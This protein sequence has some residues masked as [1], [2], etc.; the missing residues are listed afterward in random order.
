MARGFAAQAAYH[1]P[2]NAVPAPSGQGF[3]NG[4]YAVLGAGV[5]NWLSH[6]PQSSGAFGARVLPTVRRTDNGAPVQGGQA[7][8]VVAAANAVATPPSGLA[9]EFYEAPGFGS[10]VAG[11]GIESQARTVYSPSEPWTL[12][13]SAALTPFFELFPPGVPPSGTAQVWGA[14]TGFGSNTTLNP[15]SGTVNATLQAIDSLGNVWSQS[16][17]LANYGFFSAGWVQVAQVLWTPQ[18]Q[19]IKGP[20]VSGYGPVPVVSLTVGLVALTEYATTLAFDLPIVGPY[21]GSAGNL[22][23][24]P[25]QVQA[26]SGVLAIPQ[27]VFALAYPAAPAAG[28]LYRN[29]LVYVDPATSAYGYAEGG[30]V[31]TAQT[32]QAPGAGVAGAVPAWLV[33]VSTTSA[34]VTAAT[35]TDLRN[36]LGAGY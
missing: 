18:F 13:S 36:E 7:M 34:G 2:P 10:G 12:A 22:S 24:L 1:L 4:G 6:A 11:G 14:Q 27:A 3:V 15:D 31:T 20:G 9:Y 26:A 25:A 29:D 21:S 19:L 23:L 17:Q 8:A 16:E 33:T 32:S 28:T 5:D 30:V 35:L